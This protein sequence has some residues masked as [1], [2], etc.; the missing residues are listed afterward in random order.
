MS[1]FNASCASLSAIASAKVRSAASPGT[2][3]AS[4]ARHASESLAV[5]GRPPGFPLW[6]GFQRC[7]APRSRFASAVFR[8]FSGRLGFIGLAPR[9]G[10]YKN[11]FLFPGAD[12]DIAKALEQF[13]SLWN[14]LGTKLSFSGEFFSAFQ[15]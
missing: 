9:D 11:V 14:I 3:D 4:L 6:P 2:T 7:A 12:Q 15:V 1:P 5:R 10:F 13:W 8:L